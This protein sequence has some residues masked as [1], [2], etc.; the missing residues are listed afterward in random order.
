MAPRRGGGSGE[1]R[2]RRRRKAARSRPAPPARTEG[3]FPPRPL[4]CPDSLPPCPPKH[5]HT[6][7]HSLTHSREEPGGGAE[8]RREGKREEGDRRSRRNAGPAAPPY[9]AGVSLGLGR[10]EEGVGQLAEPHGQ[11]V[12][13]VGA[14][15][16]HH[17]VEERLQVG[18]GIAPHMDDLVPRRRG[19]RARRLRG[20][21]R[22][23]RHRA[24][25]L[26]G[27]L[28]RGRG[29][30][31]LRRLLR[32]GLPG[33][34]GCDG[35]PRRFLAGLGGSE[36]AGPAPHAPR[37]GSSRRPRLFLPLGGDGR[38]G[39]DRAALSRARPS[40][41]G[42]SVPAAETNSRNTPNKSSQL[43]PPE[44]LSAAD[45]APPEP[46]RTVSDRDGPAPRGPPARARPHRLPPTGRRGA[47]GA[48]RP[49]SP[50]GARLAVSSRPGSS[51]RHSA[52]LRAPARPV[53]LLPPARPSR[54]WR[55]A[56]NHN[57]YF[58]LTSLPTSKLPP[59]GW[60]RAATLPSPAAPEGDSPPLWEMAGEENGGAR[61]RPRERGGEAPGLGLTWRRGGGAALQLEGTRALPHLEKLLLLD[62]P[63]LGKK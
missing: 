14:L 3:G 60:G 44:S 10:L 23:S 20:A 56:A 59:R 46:A 32:L 26:R 35:T 41:A 39:S 57:F 11:R 28:L 36:R 45:S 12:R 19:A 8:G 7:S 49:P 13:H 16:V 29:L 55:R 30:R 37:H 52:A 18:L 34:H 27:R 62:W 63:K 58:S 15:G 9:L 24:R 61:R 53:S 42:A 31:R 25:G 5:S 38:N 22:S 33:I 47:R 21:S 48:V 17:G 2:R 54:P 50:H 1:K 40:P 6:H 51:R 4:P 43:R